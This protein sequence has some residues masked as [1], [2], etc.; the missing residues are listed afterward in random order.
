VTDKVLI[1]EDNTKVAMELERQIK[2]LGYAV[3]GPVATGAAALKNAETAR[4]D[5]VLM[6]ISIQGPADGIQTAE[7]IRDRF[8]IPV[9]YLT[10]HADQ[11]TI[12][13]AKM[14]EPLGYLL[15]P[16]REHELQAAITV[17]LHKHKMTKAL[18][19]C[20][21]DFLAML[22]HDIQNP[23][24]LVLGYTD[25]LAE[26]LNAN[27][28]HQA[29]QLLEQMRG[30]IVSTS[31]LVANYSTL[32][33]IEGGRLPLVTDPVDINEILKQ[34]ETRY[35][36]EARRRRLCLETKLAD[37]LPLADGDASA[38]QRVF[39]NLVHNALKFTPQGGHV[40][41]TSYRNGEMVAASV[42]DTGPGIPSD[43]MPALFEKYGRR[44][45]HAHQD[46]S[47]LGLFIV[48]SLVEAQGGRVE[49]ESAPGTGACFKVSLPAHPAVAGCAG[50][51]R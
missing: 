29:Q 1:V 49:V 51:N 47:G 38:L 8:G 42:T 3:I 35:V 43:E 40:L 13:R 18:E 4:P 22:T 20:Q 21:S 39:A 7:A 2:Q 45:I 11:T 26:E 17:A 16:W 32:L 50:K 10:A 14:T 15:K 31:E 41:I 30:N 48:K 46:G 37:N 28:L 27:G 24:Q 5:L 33:A 36:A 34:V 9:I 19:Q 44:K 23:L 6:D 12:E 25:V